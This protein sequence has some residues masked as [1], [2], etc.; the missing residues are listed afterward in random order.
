MNMRPKTALL[1]LS[2][3]MLLPNCGRAHLSGQGGVDQY[4]AV[5]PD[6]AG[7]FIQYDM[8]FGELITASMMVKI[9]TD[10]NGKISKEERNQFL[11]DRYAYHMS[12][13]KL[14]FR[15]T[16]YSRET[17]VDFQLQE[18]TV[19]DS[20]QARIVHN[21]GKKTLRI[22]W[23]FKAPWPSFLLNTKEPFQLE[24]QN[25]YRPMISCLQMAVDRSGHG[26]KILTTS[27]PS[28]KELPLPP[29][30]TDP[31]TDLSKVPR[32]VRTFFTLTFSEK[33]NQKQ[34]S[35]SQTQFAD[36]KRS[37]DERNPLQNETPVPADPASLEKESVVRGREDSSSTDESSIVKRL[38]EYFKTKIRAL[39]K[40]PLSLYSWILALLLTFVWGACHAASPGHGKAIVSAYLVSSRGRYSDAVLLGILVTITHTAVVFAL[41]LAAILMGDNFETPE[42]LQ[43][44]GAV[45]IMLVGFNQIRRGILGM[46]GKD[47]HGHAHT[48]P[49]DDHEHP[50]EAPPHPHDHEHSHE[51]H[52]HSHDHQHPHE[53]HAHPHAHEHPHDKKSNAHEH[54]HTHGLGSIFSHHHDHILAPGADYKDIAAVGISGGMIPCPAAIIM[55]LLAWQLGMPMLG[56]SCLISFSAGLALTL[57]GVGILA[58]AGFRF[59]LKWVSSDKKTGRATTLIHI[60]PL[61]GG[62]LLI[63]LGAIFL[64]Y[65]E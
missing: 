65:T 45:I 27:L 42:W 63:V 23:K 30:I 49:P 9:D 57:M 15:K 6:I 22:N 14:F 46:L 29:D 47:P 8:H 48:Q 3:L 13:V 43:P 24:F 12:K 37:S 44:L 35:D 55:I 20:V 38:E 36:K 59:V 56:L 39:F 19:L 53:A 2:I 4:I 41:A 58:L 25:F 52:P 40:P 61:V 5:K 10:K 50:H 7:V 17:E 21:Q 51:A 1:L 28:V 34:D 32:V 33:K 60:L 54:S 18:K 11:K 31:V 64:T 26:V 62:I 16:R